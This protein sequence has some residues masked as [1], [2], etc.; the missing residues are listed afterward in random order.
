LCTKIVIITVI[1]S[2]NTGAIFFIARIVSAIIVIITN[3]RYIIAETFDTVIISTWIRIAT[4]DMGKYASVGFD[5][6]VVNGTKFIIIANNRFIVTSIF[7]MATNS[8]A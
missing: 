6:T 3:Y 1:R 8:V 2:K 4:V 5:I 7:F